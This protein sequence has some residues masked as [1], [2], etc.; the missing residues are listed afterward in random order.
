MEVKP[1]MLTYLLSKIY[2]IP[3]YMG[4]IVDEPMQISKA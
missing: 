1:C 3:Q 2:N 4:G